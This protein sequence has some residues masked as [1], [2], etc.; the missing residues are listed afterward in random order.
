MRRVGNPDQGVKA[1]RPPSGMASRRL[2]AAGCCH[3]ESLR[4]WHRQSF[5]V[6]VATEHAYFERLS[7]CVAQEAYHSRTPFGLLSQATPTHVRI[8]PDRWQSF[9]R[10]SVGATLFHSFNA[11]SLRPP[12]RK[13]LSCGLSTSRGSTPIQGQPS[14]GGI[15]VPP[16]AMLRRRRRSLPFF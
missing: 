13:A 12:R 16:T 10:T 11:N 1:N 6:D 4:G 2:R 3:S 14:A 9:L 7:V 8:T 5:G 15:F